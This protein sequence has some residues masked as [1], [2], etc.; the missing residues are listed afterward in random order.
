MVNSAGCLKRQKGHKEMEE[1][2]QITAQLIGKNIRRIRLE[3]GETQQE[4]GAFLGYGATTI[5]NYE[6]GYRLPDLET[7]FQ[8]ALH[9]GASLEDFIRD[10]EDDKG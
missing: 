1:K 8:I 5:A 10:A 7:F 4:L 2:K 6:S 3:N 9:Y